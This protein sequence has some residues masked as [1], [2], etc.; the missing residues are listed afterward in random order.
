MLPKHFAHN[1]K[2]RAARYFFALAAAIL[3]GISASAAREIIRVGIA[4]E[5]GVFAAFDV[6]T[7]KASGAT[8]EILEAIAEDIGVEL[9][10]VIVAGAGAVPYAKAIADGRIDVV[11]NTYQ[12]TPEAY[13]RAIRRCCR[14]STRHW[15]D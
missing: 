15:R 11:A 3:V 2:I 6:T 13:A 12:I 4:A 9:Q 14:R 5:P 1:T 7:K 8:A 10:Y